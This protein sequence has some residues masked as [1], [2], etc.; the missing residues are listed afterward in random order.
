MFTFS[1]NKFF[2]FH[3]I[4]SQRCFVAIIFTSDLSCTGHLHCYM[5]KF[6]MCIP[7]E[8]FIEAFP[9][10]YCNVLINQAICF[11]TLREHLS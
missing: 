11:M 6:Q 2:L 3:L 5:H 7:C 9:I 8:A 10:F 1:Y 4:G